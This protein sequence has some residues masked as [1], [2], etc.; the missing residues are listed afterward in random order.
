MVL[1]IEKV[2]RGIDLEQVNRHLQ[3]IELAC[4]HAGP[5]K[6]RTVISKIKRFARLNA[7]P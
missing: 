6:S 7:A 2:V 5:V 3:K 1:K 4:A